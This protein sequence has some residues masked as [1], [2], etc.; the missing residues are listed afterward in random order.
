MK[1][2]FDFLFPFDTCSRREQSYSFWR[3]RREPECSSFC[4]LYV[5]LISHCLI[6]DESSG[7]NIISIL[8]FQNGNDGHLATFETQSHDHEPGSTT[9]SVKSGKE[10]Q[11]YDFNDDQVTKSDFYL[12]ILCQ[13]SLTMF[14][15]AISIKSL[16]LTANAE[17]DVSLLYANMCRKM[18][19][20]LLPLVTKRSD[21]SHQMPKFF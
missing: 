10:D 2:L 6:F 4:K 16:I 1:L 21:I 19:I 13:K 18:M 3:N 14:F 17:F 5:F 15:S 20:L 7:S 9:A 12:F 8:Y 11:T